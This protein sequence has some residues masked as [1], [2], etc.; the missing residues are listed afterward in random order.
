MIPHPSA[1]GQS[2]GHPMRSLNGG[3][4]QPDPSVD[5]SQPGSRQPIAIDL[6]GGGPESQDREPPP[7]RPRLDVSG[8]SNLGDTA[9]TANS[10]ET[11]NTPGSAGPRQQVTWRG[12]PLWSFQ[13][14][15]SEIPGSEGR[16]DGAPSKPASPP[17]FPVQPWT[18]APKDRS[19]NA[20]TQVDEEFLPDTKVQ[21]TPYRIQ[22]PSAAPKIKGDRVADFAPWTGH[23]PEDTLNEQTAKQGY[24]DRTQV[25]QNE[26][27][28]A[29]PAL[30]TQ[31]KH[32][33][34]LQMLSNVFTAVLEKRQN[35][36]TVHAPST[37]KPPP[38]VT[39][40]DN[41]REGWLRDLANPSVPL[42]RLSRTI[43][44]GIRGKVLLDQCLGKWIPVARA[45]WLAK[46]VGANE[47][48]AFKRKGTSG[49]LAVGLE[50]KWVRD[51][52]CNVQQFV[53]GVFNSPKS[54]NW[55]SKMTYV[56]GLTARLFFE[57][58]LDH[59]NFLEWFLSSFE[60]AS[61][62]TV[63]IWLLM[64]GIYWNNI[65]R[66]RR[67]GRQLAE[68]LLEKLRQ[69]TEVQL[70]TLKPLVDRLTR[71]ITKLAR[72]HTSSLVLPNSWDLYKS[73]VSSCLNLEQKPD[74][75]LFQSLAE[76]N[77]R[78][79]RP[80]QSK[81]AG[82]GSPQKRVIQLLDSIQSTLDIASVSSACLDG[83][84]NRAILV[85]KLLEWLATPFRHGACRVYIGVRLLRKWKASGVDIDDH[86]I[87]FLTQTGSSKK[88]N[89]DNIYH[90]ISEL[91]RSQTF[92]VGRYLQWLMAKGITSSASGEPKTPQDSPCDV[93]LIVQ[94][95]VGRLPEHVS[96]LRGTLLTRMG[97]SASGETTTITNVKDLISRR[98]P[99]IFDMPM[100]TESSIEVLPAKLSWAVK[101]DVCQWLR[102]AVA[103]Y[104]RDAT[105][106]SLR[107]AF[108]NDKV[109]LISAISPNDFYI[110]RD[111]LETFGDISM[112]ADILR[113]T[114]TSE[115]YTVL[116]SIADTTN[117]HF[118]SLCAIG[119]T[120]D[121]YRKIV[122]AYAGLK[123]FG[124]PN[125]DLMFSLIELGMR[126]PN[127][128]EH[129]R[130]SPSGPLPSVIAASS[131]VSDHIPDSLGDADPLFR[132]KLD[133]FLLSGNIMDEPTL[134]SIF[135]TLTKHLESGNDKAQLSANDTCR[136]LAQLRSFQP[137]HFDG[138]LA[139]WVCSH[140]RAADRCTLLRI[141]P[142]L[143]GVGCVTIRSFLSLVKR[144]SYSAKA[145]PNV[146]S[147]PAD[148][149]ALLVTRTENDGCLDLVSYRFRLAQQE[150][151]SKDSEQALGIVCS[152]AAALDASNSTSASQR[153]K[154]ENAMVR[155][156]LEL[157]VRNPKCSDPKC[158]QRLLS[159]HPAA[160]AL[161][162]KALDV[163]LDPDFEQRSSGDET[164]EV[165]SKSS[166]G[167]GSIVPDI[168]KL[169][170]TT[171]DFSLPFSQ[172]KLQVLFN[173][174]SGHES[175]D[176]FVDAM[177]KTV[178]ADSSSHKH[179]WVDLV[180]L[181]NP[182]AVRQIR[183]RAEK[184]FFAVPLL[185]ESTETASSP[186]NM[187]TLET[188]KLYL[189]IIEELAGSIPDS[190]TPAVGS[191]IIEKMDALLQ[192][193]LTLQ[194]KS[195]NSAEK[196]PGVSSCK[197]RS[198][199][200]RSLA[201]WFSALLRMVVLHRVSFMQPS[202]SLKPGSVQEQSRLLISI[203]CIA[204][205]RLPGEILRLFPGA[206]Y[207]P[208]P[209]ATEGYRPCPGILLQT[210][211]LDVAA[212]LIDVFPDEVRLQCARFLKEKCPPFVP[213]QN[214]TRFLYLLGPMSDPTSSAALQSASAP[215]P[216]AS[217]S[218]PTPTSA[219]YPG[220]STYP[221][222]PAP[223]QA[224]STGLAESSNCMLN[225]L[226]IEHRGRIGAP[227]PIRSW[228][229]LEDAA[230]L[231]GVN[232]TAVNLSYFDARRV[233]V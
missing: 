120:S 152:A 215:S 159:Q 201:F 69:T 226:R 52:T 2:W 119:A 170:S 145:I 34:G 10:A 110:V 137:K 107:T 15:I 210:H 75:I 18:N 225:R 32:R 134:D 200:E 105:H 33:A 53:E 6:T 175:K 72:E 23:H 104:T 179:H 154:L 214:D 158:V 193:I 97:F 25:S 176:K 121:L 90:A 62:S 83:I 58:L 160:L 87:A 131:P 129:C 228:E 198:Q 46:C 196:R 74:R 66:Y 167:H 136:Y 199:F 161:I 38:R 70:N 132:E 229:L 91:V 80:R 78:V 88:L 180:A 36:S 177:F 186:R 49:A 22:V 115:D 17:P 96:N 19:R 224:S 157:L 211:A 231:I 27:N 81:Q 21:T 28:T 51:W 55:K 212:S 85:A 4:A 217:A 233:R 182:D 194:P 5:S 44:H 86:I 113:I 50:A 109:P 43:P 26:S 187:G 171:D 24:Y 183:E 73:Q 173:A 101:A 209:G 150:F 189:T 84:S 184:E 59:D 165:G 63:P 118:E 124:M 117:C 192:K 39:L 156:L 108:S 202:P 174:A 61:I 93:G 149:V 207:F 16:T 222:Q 13:A 206:D 30:Y 48:R 3:P 71:F 77:A 40:T 139:R 123:R 57:N 127:E 227:Y 68:I 29:R 205:S 114:S 230:P 89:I 221:Q 20:G 92:S 64:L 164:A 106:S 143:I 126:I 7:K 135:N 111:I 163:L 140:L 35:H 151:L 79:H 204:L 197:G 37:F 41:K 181:M 67:R 213:L 138:I 125:L 112:L 12:R 141:L 76:R 223:L 162:Q 172:L 45:V 219:N 144:I 95:P 8:S 128:N 220:S 122:D 178:V 14:V 169:A 190:G 47:I 116:A 166:V 168:E 94:L 142:P 130:H 232:D 60:A 218:T 195:H 103:G 54:L 133:H 153:V 42:R 102:R 185:E 155:L 56:V 148:L 65:M 216:A 82:Q 9:T 1:G 146:A 203:F 208:R 147:L 99:A 98:L 188:A 31:F 191:A 11:R 100:E